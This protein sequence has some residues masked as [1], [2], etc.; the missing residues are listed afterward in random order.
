MNMRAG[1]EKQLRHLSRHDRDID[2]GDVRD[3]LSQ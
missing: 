1:D 2:R 3:D